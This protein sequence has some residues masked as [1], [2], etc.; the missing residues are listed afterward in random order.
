MCVC[1]CVC[2]R[3]RV[4]VCVCVCVLCVCCVCVANIFCSSFDGQTAKG[5]T[6][7]KMV[8]AEPCYFTDTGR[9]LHKLNTALR[10]LCFAAEQLCLRSGTLGIKSL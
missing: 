9:H 4:C 1:V 6:V 5:S 8:V 3:A 10:N 7:V 2:A